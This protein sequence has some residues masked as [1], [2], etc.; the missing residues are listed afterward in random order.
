LAA[1]EPLAFLQVDAGLASQVDRIAWAQ[2]VIAVAMVVMALVVIGIGLLSFSAIRSVNRVLGRVEKSIERLTP[3]VE[4]LLDKA[5]RVADDASDVSD[6]V[7]RRVNE[8]MDTVHDFNRSLRS[9][10]AAVEER[11]RD[12]GAV[13]D[14]VQEEAEDLLLDTAATARGLKATAESLRGDSHQIAPRM[15]NTPAPTS[16]AEEA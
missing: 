9:A 11:V 7:R 10:G 15:V 6:T 16:T 8:L 1:F 14:V 13:I 5:A 12:F 2:I 3:R 4:P